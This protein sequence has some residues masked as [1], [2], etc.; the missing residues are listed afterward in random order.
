MMKQTNYI[1]STCMHGKVPEPRPG[2]CHNDSRTLPDPTLNFIKT[3]SLM[4]ENVP[5]F[6]GQP[7][8][9]RTSTINAAAYFVVQVALST[10]LAKKS[11]QFQPVYHI[12]LEC[13]IYS[14]SQYLQHDTSAAEALKMSTAL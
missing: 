7:I 3:H 4:D 14:N 2:S 13:N 1:N 6:F 10:S 9:V 8:L 5:A 11:Q 12:Q